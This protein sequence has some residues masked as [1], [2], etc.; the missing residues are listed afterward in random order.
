MK[1]LILALLLFL[2]NT[3]ILSQ[4]ERKF[5][6]G[7]IKLDS[8]PIHNVHILNR[9]TNTGTVSNDLGMFMLPVKLGDRLSISH[10]NLKNR[11]ISITKKNIDALAISIALTNQATLLR[12]FTLKKTRGIFEQ[13][14]DI[15]IYTGPKVNAQTLKLPYANTKIST[16]DA[17]FKI[18]SGAV[19]SLS[20]LVSVLNGSKKRAKALRKR[21]FEDTQLVKIRNFFTDDFFITDLHIQEKHIN[22]FLN[23]CVKKN[24]IRFFNKKDNLRLTKTLLRE[25][26]LFPQEDSSLIEVAFKKK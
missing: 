22:S 17:V 24:I 23:F 8:F 12:A 7:E 4:E 14:K 5:I 20:N 10:L 26:N 3:A 13:D 21:S 11:T 9:T 1:Y 2:F 16:D 19:I 15:L 18:Q 6:T 25:S